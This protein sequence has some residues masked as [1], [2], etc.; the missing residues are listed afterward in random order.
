MR[1][2]RRN[3]MLA[4]LLALFASMAGCAGKNDP[5]SEPSDMPAVARPAK[6]GDAGKEDVRAV[7][8]ANNAF[9]LDLHRAMSP[10]GNQFLSPISVSTALGM[11]YAGA[12]GD[13]AK[14]MSKVLHYPF[15]GERLHLG[16]AGLLGGLSDIGATGKVKLSVANALWGP[17]DYAQEFRA[18]NRDYYAAD[19]RKIALVGAEPVINKWAE[20]HTAGRIKDLLPPRSLDKRSLLVLTNAIY[21]KGEWKSQFK[22]S[23]TRDEEY[24]VPGRPTVRVPMMHQTARLRYLHVGKGSPAASKLLNLPYAGGLSMLVVL[25]DADDGLEAVERGLTAEDLEGWQGKMR[26]TEVRVGLP[27]FRL[28]GA[29]VNL[30]AP[31]QKLGMVDAFEEAKANFSGLGKLDENVFLDKVLHKAFVEVNEQGSEAAAATAVKLDKT[32]DAVPDTDVSFTADHP[33]LFLIRD[34]RTGCILFLGRL[35]SPKG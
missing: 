32:T 34:D 30:N 31:L 21:F 16:Y 2:T 27:R 29:T 28:L 3:D 11:T 20:D 26:E 7:A 33:F 9:A 24:R 8:L 13:T 22:K 23:K 14:G 4:R 17:L 35:L 15:E 18:V 5:S 12:R 25:P 19:V 1:C 6:A 10:K